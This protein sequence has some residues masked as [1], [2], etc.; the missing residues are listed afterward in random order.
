MLMNESQR[1]NHSRM[2]FI[3]SGNDDGM[4]RRAVRRRRGSLPGLE[5]RVRGTTNAVIRDGAHRA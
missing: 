4:P 5:R 1:V 3:S 2:G